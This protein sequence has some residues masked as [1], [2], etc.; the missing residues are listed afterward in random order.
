MPMMPMFFNK[1]QGAHSTNVANV[2]FDGFEDVVL[3]EVQP[4]NP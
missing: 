2:R 1:V 4:V 3:T